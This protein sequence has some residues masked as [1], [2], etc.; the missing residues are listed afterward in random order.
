MKNFYG[1]DAGTFVNIMGTAGGLGCAA[2]VLLLGLL[3]G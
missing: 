3:L 2:V 1:S